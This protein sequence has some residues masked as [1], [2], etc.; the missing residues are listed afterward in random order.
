M[1]DNTDIEH[2]KRKT[3]KYSS[4]RNLP[5]TFDE[6]QRSISTLNVNSHSPFYKKDKPKEKIKIKVKPF[7]EQARKT[8]FIIP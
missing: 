8:S 5:T 3:G 2:L 1:S 4:P 7:E 6:T